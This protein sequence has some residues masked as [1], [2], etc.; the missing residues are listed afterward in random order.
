MI[1]PVEMQINMCFFL[2]VS[3]FV[4]GAVNQ[5]Q[6]GGH[7]ADTSCESAHGPAY[8]PSYS[9]SCGPTRAKVRPSEAFCDETKHQHTLENSLFPI[10]RDI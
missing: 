9:P 4:G 5:K 6:D 2:C 7:A 3:G 1:N 8:D 10:R